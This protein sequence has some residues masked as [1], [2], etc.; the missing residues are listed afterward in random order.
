MV[1]HVGDNNWAL[2]VVLDALLISDKGTLELTDIAKVSRSWVVS[3]INKL[4]N[5]NKIHILRWDL[6]PPKNSFQRAI[7]RFGTGINAPFVHKTK[8]NKR[9][10]KRKE[11]KAEAKNCDIVIPNVKRCYLVAALFGKTEMAKGYK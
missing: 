10:V 9:T 4:I 11:A 8:N 3:V 5:E 1:Q 7:Y 2:K 6:I